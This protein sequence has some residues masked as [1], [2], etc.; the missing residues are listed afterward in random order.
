MSTLIINKKAGFEYEI[1]ETFE[2]GVELLGTE[3]K[4]LRGKKGSLAG[5]YVSFVGSELFLLGAHIP[6]YQ[7]KNAPLDFDPYRTRKLLLRRKELD[8]L[9]SR[10]KTKGLTAVATKVY[11]MG[12]QIKVHIALVRGKKLFDKRETIKKRDLD[13]SMRRG[14]AE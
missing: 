2:A 10:L 5:S 12:R 4:A 9:A 3:V 13:R 7:P 1:L 11:S 14:L 8:G 6:P